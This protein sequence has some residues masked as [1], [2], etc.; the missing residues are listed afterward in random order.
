[1][2]EE[3]S[4]VAKTKDLVNEIT[5][6]AFVQEGKFVAFPMCF[7]GASVPIPADE[8][9]ITALDIIDN[10]DFHGGTS[11]RAVHLFAG[12][13]AGTTGLVFD[14]GTVEDADQCAAVCCGQKDYVAA[15]NGPDGGRLVTGRMTW[16][17]PD[18][19]Q[20]WGLSRKPL[21]D[22]GEPVPG[23]RIEH[24]IADAARQRVIGST[25]RRLFVVDLDGMKTHVIGEIDGGGRITLGA[26]GGVYGLDGTAHLWRC[27]PVTLE[28]QRRAVP[29]PDGQWER[30]AIVWAA[31][32]RTG[33]LYAADA[34][35]TLFRFDEGRGFGPPAGRTPLTP[36]GPMAVTHD[37]RVFGF[38]GDEMAKLFCFNPRRG[39]VK[40]LGVAA[41][42]LERRRYGYVFGDAITGPDGEIFF[43]EKDNLGHLWVYFPRIEGDG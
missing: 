4:T 14:L 33:V 21:T 32:R 3:A 35:G 24:A 12:S 23:D 30:G 15:V 18:F 39:E 27:D 38:C 13:F 11:G 40:T 2:A 43:G 31:N 25:G 42:V 22:L 8:S 16:I 19:V 6:G 36:L 20:E 28:V 17:Q 1:M 41:S 10:G 37:G 34:A 26:K 5:R 29:L 7:P 9:H